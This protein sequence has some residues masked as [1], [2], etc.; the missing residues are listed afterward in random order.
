MIEPA[1]RAILIAASPVTAI[2]GTRIRPANLAAEEA[3]SGAACV[4]Y[5]VLPGEAIHCLNAAA[6]YTTEPFRCDCFASTYP[7]AKSLAAAVK[8]ALDYYGGTIGG[9][10]VV[11]IEWQGTVDETPPADIGAETPIY[12]LA[13]EFTSFI[14]PS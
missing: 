3:S 14:K 7:I 4:A 2:A 11:N 9:I 6:E 10:E 8:T 5:Q 1:I 12:H 13:V